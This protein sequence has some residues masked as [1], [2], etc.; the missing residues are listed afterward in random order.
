MKHKVWLGDC[1]TSLGVY[2]GTMTQFAEET[3]ALCCRDIIVVAANVREASTFA[4]MKYPNWEL[5]SL[6]CLSVLPWFRDIVLDPDCPQVAEIRESL[7]QH[8]VEVPADD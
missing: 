4:A 2:V 1:L 7:M 6:T 5:Q 8:L 3:G